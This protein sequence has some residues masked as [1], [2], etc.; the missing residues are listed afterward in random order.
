M[1]DIERAD[2]EDI[3]PGD[4]VIIPS[5]KK[6]PPSP[7]P[8]PDF[9]AFSSQKSHIS[10]PHL[11]PQL[12]RNEPIELFDFLLPKEVV[13]LIVTH[14]NLNARMHYSLNPDPDPD[15]TLDPDNTLDPD[16]ILD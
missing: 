13:E 6:P 9:T 15:T 7:G 1:P 10:T 16:T 4:P 2:D 14:T 11:P 8:I 3:V 5:T 12:N